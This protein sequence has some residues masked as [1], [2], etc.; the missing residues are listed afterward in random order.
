M[1]DDYIRQK[2]HD[3]LA[4]R[5]HIMSGG[6][7]DSTGLLIGDGRKRKRGRP[8]RAN[9][10]AVERRARAKK[11]AP[12]RRGGD[13]GDMCGL[14]RWQ[15]HLNATKKLTKNKHMTHAQAVREAQNTYK[16]KK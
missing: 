13:E 2:F 15:R 12:K 5:A 1:A 8:T 11:A 16:Y 7:I 10:M 4:E 6:D 9:A 3:I 14:G